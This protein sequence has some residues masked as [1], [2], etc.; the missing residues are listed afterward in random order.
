M[1]DAMKAFVALPVDIV[2]IGAAFSLASILQIGGGAA[3]TL[4]QWAALIFV[5]LICLAILTTVGWQLS[6]TS[7]AEKHFFKLGLLLV[8]NFLIP[9]LAIYQTY[10]FLRGLA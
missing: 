7:L 8:V 10:A 5:G 9:L 1:A 6:E 2:F 3:S 4:H